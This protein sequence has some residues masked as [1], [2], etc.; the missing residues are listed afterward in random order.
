MECLKMYENKALY[1]P[2]AKCGL[3]SKNLTESLAINIFTI[4]TVNNMLLY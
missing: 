3:Q 4:I 1:E 2:L